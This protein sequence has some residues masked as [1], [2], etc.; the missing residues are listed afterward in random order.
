VSLSAAASAGMV[1][2]LEAALFEQP[3]DLACYCALAD[4]LIDCGDSRGKFMQAQ[5]A[6]ENP[7]T[8]PAQRPGYRERVRKLLKKHLREWLGELA[9]HQPCRT[10]SVN[11]GYLDFR[12]GWLD[13]LMLP[14]LTADAARALA[15][16]PAARLL[17]HLEIHEVEEAARPDPLSL[18]LDAPFLGRLRA[19]VL[20]L[21][22]PDVNGS[23]TVPDGG[24][25]H[26]L[27]DRM[28]KLEEL[29][30][31]A[32]GVDAAALFRLPGLTNLG[33]LH[34]GYLGDHPPEALAGNPS[35]GQLTHLLLHAEAPGVGLRAR[36]LEAVVRSPHLTNLRHLHWLHTDSG[37]EGCAAVVR[38][39]I[40]GRLRSLALAHNGI[41]DAGARL[42]AACPDLPRLESLDVSGNLLSAE[43]VAVLRATG[44]R[45]Y[46][47][48][49]G[50]T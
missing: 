5:I 8:P 48:A 17:R 12:R 49:E 38:S 43:G 41:T 44:V 30:L 35:L 1:A 45:L 14:R 34:A 6:L 10:G 26:T 47:D 39:G 28:P 22:P 9:D 42:L 20:G 18:L 23:D 25:V 36:H 50:A 3:D 16:A 7:T 37:D 11:P 29:R 19:F 2:A 46:A 32:L 21:A 15:S 24:C 40:L 33:V 13:R 4:V 27:V 31:H